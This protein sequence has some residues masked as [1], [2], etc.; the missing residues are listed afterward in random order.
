VSRVVSFPVHEIEAATL[1]EALKEYEMGAADA[2]EEPVEEDV[3]VRCYLEDASGR[4]EGLTAEEARLLA[5]EHPD[6]DTSSP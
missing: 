4:T 3:L 6:V 2:V 5:E 1:E